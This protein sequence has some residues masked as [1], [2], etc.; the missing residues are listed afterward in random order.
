[1]GTARKKNRKKAPT[2]NAAFGKNV[3][4]AAIYTVPYTILVVLVWVTQPPT[5]EQYL[6]SDP[7]I[8][9][10]G[11][12]AGPMWAVFGSLG[13]AFWWNWLYP[14]DKELLLRNLKFAVLGALGANLLLWVLS[15]LVGSQIP[16]F[17]PPEESASSGLLFGLSAGLLEEVVFR[18]GLLSVLFLALS[19]RVKG[20]NVALVLTCAIT[21]LA[22]ALGHQVGEQSFELAYFATRFAVPGFA[23]S[24]VFVKINPTFLVSAHCAAHI[25][26]AL[27]FQS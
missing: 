7:L 15:L 17:V 20:S 22:F 14:V 25:G 26:I 11:P 19:A 10:I 4:A 21:G 3:A 13:L 16:S 2:D 18:L 12:Q 6:F 1:M 8:Q 9:Y 24:L 5:L 27:F 23:M